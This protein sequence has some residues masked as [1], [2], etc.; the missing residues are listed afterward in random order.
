MYGYLMKC[1]KSF[2][3]CEGPHPPFFKKDFFS[4]TSFFR[5]HLFL[6]FRHKFFLF[7]SFSLSAQISACWLVVIPRLS[8]ASQS[9]FQVSLS[10]LMAIF[11]ANLFGILF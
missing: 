11:S 6:L 8:D 3:L 2:P 1:P 9:D 10:Y 4:F 7:A 5:P